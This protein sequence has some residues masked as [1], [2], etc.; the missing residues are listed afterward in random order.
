MIKEVL[1]DE[2]KVLEGQWDTW[3][4]WDCSMCKCAYEREVE[5]NT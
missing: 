4:R 2:T 1:N 3:T 5:R